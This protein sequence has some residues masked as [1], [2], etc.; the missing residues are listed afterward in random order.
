MSRAR[1]QRVLRVARADVLDRLKDLGGVSPVRW[2]V[3]HNPERL[4]VIGLIG[5]KSA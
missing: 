2:H 4:K 1:S 5:E 3:V